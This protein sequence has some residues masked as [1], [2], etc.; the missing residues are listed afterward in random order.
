[1]CAVANLGPDMPVSFTHQED[2]EEQTNDCEGYAG[3]ER[4]WPKPISRGNI[5][6]EKRSQGY[7]AITREFIE[8]HRKASPERA[9]KID[10]HDDRTGPGQTLADA[11]KHV[12]DENP[13]PGWSPHEQKGHRQRNDPSR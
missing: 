5:S 9:Y 10:L 12:C 11:Q 7:G 4:F 8:S 6:G 13:V 2:G 3:M 1:M